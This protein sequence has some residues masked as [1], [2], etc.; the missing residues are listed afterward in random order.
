M[1]CS[2]SIIIFD[3][4]QSFTIGVKIAIISNL[5]KKR[6]KCNQG[7]SKI[8][9]SFRMIWQITLINKRYLHWTLSKVDTQFLLHCWYYGQYREA[10]SE[11]TVWQYE[12]ECCHWFLW[13]IHLLL[14]KTKCN[15]KFS[16]L[17]TK[18]ISKY[19]NKFT[20]KMNRK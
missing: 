6:K 8:Q 3:V 1:K 5:Y 11:N 18:N 12:E 17:R 4:D 10:D 16:W 7:W 15:N 9:D 20:V 2:F 13:R 14:Q 19:I